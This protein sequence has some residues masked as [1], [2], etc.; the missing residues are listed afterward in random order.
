MVKK[1]QRQKCRSNVHPVVWGG[2]CCCGKDCSLF[3]VSQMSA[4]TYVCVCVYVYAFTLS[5][6][7]FQYEIGQMSF[8][9]EE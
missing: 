2:A 1:Q 6:F 4:F 5:Y 7:T 9:D 8:P 3:F